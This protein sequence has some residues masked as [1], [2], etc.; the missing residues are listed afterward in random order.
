MSHSKMLVKRAFDP[1]LKWIF[2]TLKSA[3]DDNM[4]VAFPKI[5]T[6]IS[7]ALHNMLFILQ[8][9]EDLKTCSAAE[10]IHD[11]CPHFLSYTN[12]SIIVKKELDICPTF[13]RAQLYKSEFGVDGF[14][15]KNYTDQEILKAC[16]DCVN[17]AYCED[18]LK[19]IGIVTYEDPL[20]AQHEHQG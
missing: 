9:M 4:Y 19:V 20:D 8:E 1:F 14:Y 17:R 5:V 12:E 6:T 16:G 15:V 13:L 3:K 18:G 2:H 11:E 7:S 10:G